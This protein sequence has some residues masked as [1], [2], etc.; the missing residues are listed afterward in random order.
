MSKLFELNLFGR[1]LE[2]KFESD[3]ESDSNLDSD[4]DLKSDSQQQPT[5]AS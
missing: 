5:R 1:W 4:S 3:S 2:S